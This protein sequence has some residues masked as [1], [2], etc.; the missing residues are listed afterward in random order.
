MQSILPGIKGKFTLRPCYPSKNI[1][2]FSCQRTYM[3][4][5]RFKNRT[6]DTHII[7]FFVHYVLTFYTFH[8]RQKGIFCEDL[9]RWDVD[10]FLFICTFIHNQRI[11][12][13][14]KSP[15]GIL[16]EMHPYPISG[17]TYPFLEILC[18]HFLYFFH[19]P[20]PFF[21]QKG[22]LQT[23]GCKLPFRCYNDCSF[24]L[25]LCI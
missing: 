5:V 24:F 14:R 3:V 25:L 4:K 16:W 6:F 9:S 7:I 23:I 12:A 10:L 21:T 1:V 15:L 11:Y 19:A 8:C 22:Q 18:I 17:I 20:L 13:V 2:L